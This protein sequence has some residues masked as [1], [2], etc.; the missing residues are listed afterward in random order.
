MRWIW[1]HCLAPRSQLN[2]PHQIVYFMDPLEEIKGYKCPLHPDKSKLDSLELGVVYHFVTGVNLNGAHDSL[3]D[4]KAQTIVITSAQFCEYIDKPKSIRL[5]ED[6]FT[7]A[8]KWDMLKKMESLRPVHE[9][10]LE[11]VEGDGFSWTPPREDRYTGVAGG[12]NWGPSSKM[13]QLAR[14]G[15][16]P[17]MFLSIVTVDTAKYIAARTTNYAYNDWVVPTARLDRDGKTV[18]RP[19]MSAIFPKRGERL[20]ANARHRCSVTKNHKKYQVIE[21]FV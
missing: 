21:H 15:D 12:A 11:L 16:L 20:P 5:V 19:I 6:I 18:R 14:G 2:I 13:L 7:G 17:S 9:P 8:E 10:W 4:V 3:V 1:K